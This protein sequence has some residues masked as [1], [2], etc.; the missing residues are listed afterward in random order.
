MDAVRRYAEPAVPD[1]QRQSG[2]RRNV[3]TCMRTDC[4]DG[5]AGVD[6][7]RVDAP[8]SAPSDGDGRLSDAVLPLFRYAPEESDAV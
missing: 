4:L 7:K 6:W 5:G 8:R 2:R 1:L 3:A